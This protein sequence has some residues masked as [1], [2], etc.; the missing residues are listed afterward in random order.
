M[1]EDTIVVFTARSPERI[2]REGGSQAWMLNPS[3]ARQCR[4]LVCTQNQHNPDHTF[5]DATRP[6]G[7]A[8]L[9]GKVAGIIPAP[10]EGR[11]ERWMIRI[12]EYALIDRPNAWDGSRN[13]VRYTSL[14][15]LNIREE[16]LEF[17]PMPAGR[18]V[19]SPVTTASDQKLEPL[20]IGEAKQRL[21]ATHGVKPEAIEIIIRA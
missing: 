15:E 18:E 11:S 16:E 14:K 2:V 8:F 5:S 19:I 13:P 10:K 7:S 3:R 4:W 17:Q 1:N 6:H 12:S 9:V 21:A 20:T